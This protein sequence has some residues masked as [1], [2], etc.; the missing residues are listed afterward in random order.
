MIEIL[1]SEPELDSVRSISPARETPYKMWRRLD[2]GRLSPVLND[3]QEG[4]NRPRQD[5]P[6]VYLQNAAID[7]LRSKTV[8]EKKSMTGDHI[9][10]Y[11]MGDNFDIDYEVELDKARSYMTINSAVRNFCFDIDGVIASLTENND[12]RLAEPLVDNVTL[13][14]RLYDL[15]HHITLFTARGYVTKKDWTELTRKQLQAWGVLYHELL[16]GKPAADY[17]IDDKLISIEELKCIF[18]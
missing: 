1:L 5:L 10:G 12:Y 6:T 15:G 9:Y 7:V 13:I 3:L 16:F 17:Y 8:L 4:Y 18:T 11:V 2:D 14:N